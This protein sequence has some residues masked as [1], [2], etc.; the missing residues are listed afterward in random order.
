MAKMTVRI[1]TPRDGAQYDA[2]MASELGKVLESLGEDFTA[3]DVVKVA[4]KKR[5]P[6]HNLF[7]WD[8]AKAGHQYRLEQARHHTR[9]LDVSIVKCGEK[10]TTR[11][12]H[13]VTIVTEEDEKKRRYVSMSAIHEDEDLRQ[14]VIDKALTELRGWRSRYTE[15]QEVFGEI[16][17]AI[18]ELELA[19]A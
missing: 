19:T 3:E 13:N 10:S 9:H 12:F 6:I 17:E 5:S 14:Q 4:K 11:A 7:E 2:Q 1:Y 8:D 15:Y 16:F 18:D